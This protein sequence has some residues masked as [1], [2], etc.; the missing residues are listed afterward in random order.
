MTNIDC[1]GDE[2]YLT[3][4]E[5]EELEEP[6]PAAAPITFRSQDFDVKGLVSRLENKDILVPRIR[7]TSAEQDVCD[8]NSFQRGFVWNKKQMD[9]FIES[10]LLEYPIP[11]LF[12]VQQA[13]RRLLVLDGQ[14][15]LETL[16]RYYSGL[17]GDK[18]YRLRLAGSKFDG[19]SYD[20]LPERFRRIIDNTYITT[21]I[22]VLDNRP[23]SKNAVYDVFKR[24]NSGGTQLTP[25]EIRMALYNGELMNLVDRSNIKPSWRKLYGST[26]L[27]KRFRDHELV[28]RITALY[29]E[30]QSYTKPLGGFLNRFADKYRDGSQPELTAALDLFDKTADII[31]ASD[32]LH[33]FF[34][35][36]RKQLN[37][38]RAESI[39]IGCM[40]ALHDGNGLDA[41]SIRQLLDKLNRNQEYIDSVTSATSDEAQVHKR[42]SLVRKALS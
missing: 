41:S 32:V 9:L 4:E 26:Q 28:L 25:H 29:L 14:Q 5:K 38:A 7:M 15:R 10:L 2:T 16:R 17:N 21:T 18:R 42:I 12:L 31:A 24:L 20:E 3:P 13:D 34:M 33:P 39:M 36:D 35:A 19:L 30:E 37:T 22:I 23:E 27:N 40:H 1:E 8:L 11:G 6:Q